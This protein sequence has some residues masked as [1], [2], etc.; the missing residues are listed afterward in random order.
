MAK[1]LSKMGDAIE[2]LPTSIEVGALDPELQE[3][4]N[5]TS[6]PC[7]INALPYDRGIAREAWHRKN[8]PRAFES[9]GG[10]RSLSDVK[11]GDGGL[12]GHGG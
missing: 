9:I 8:T 7:S 1:N 3:L 5:R 2:I 6:H 11:R 10:D 4:R 12:E